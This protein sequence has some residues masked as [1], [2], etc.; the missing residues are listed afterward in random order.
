LSG[1]VFL[2]HPRVRDAEAQAIRRALLQYA[3]TAQGR[4]FIA[5]GGFGS[6]VPLDGREL[7]AFK[8]YALDAQRA[9]RD[10]R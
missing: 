7:Q 3:A 10:A 8:P 6:L 2:T 5:H 9:L 1:Q 4:R